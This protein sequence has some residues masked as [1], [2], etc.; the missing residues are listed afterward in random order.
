MIHT[1]EKPYQCNDCQ[2]ATNDSSNYRK[3]LLRHA[4][5]GI[6]TTTNSSLLNHLQHNFDLQSWN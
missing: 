5:S 4:P 1:G 2:F 3:H 6:L